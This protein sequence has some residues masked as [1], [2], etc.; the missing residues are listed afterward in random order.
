MPE[1][2]KSDRVCITPLEPFSP[3]TTSQVDLLLRLLD[4]AHVQNTLVGDDLVRGISGGQRKRVTIGVS[5]T[6]SPSLL[7]M[8]EPTTGTLFHPLLLSPFLS[9][10]IAI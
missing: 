6:S 7:L 3:Y 4:L 9:H 10:H 2:A 8:D 1:E 5:L